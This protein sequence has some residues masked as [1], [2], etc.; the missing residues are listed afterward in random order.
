MVVHL[1]YR[2]GKISRLDPQVFNQ[3]VLLPQ[4][5]SLPVSY[6]PHCSAFVP[7][8]GILRLPIL[9]VHLTE[10]THPCVIYAQRDSR[11]QDRVQIEKKAFY[12]L[13]QEGYQPMFLSQR[14]LESIIWKVTQALSDASQPKICTRGLSACKSPLWA[15]LWAHRLLNWNCSGGY[16]TQHLDF[17]YSGPNCFSRSV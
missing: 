14:Y 6:E 1:T 2:G 10:T 11:H 3:L 8:L 16:F 4:G 13:I 12:N 17:R 9:R 7:I 15:M 5:I